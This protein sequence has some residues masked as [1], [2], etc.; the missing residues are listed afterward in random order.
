MPPARREMSKRAEFRSAASL[1]ARSSVEVARNI[2]GER[3][4]TKVEPRT[5]DEVLDLHHITIATSRRRAVFSNEADVR[6]VVR[7]LLELAAAN[8]VAF[9]AGGDHLHLVCAFALADAARR[10]DAMR[11]AVQTVIGV[12]LEP[13]RVSLINGRRH[14]ERVLPYVF[15]QG[16]HHGYDHD[17]AL[18]SGSSIGF[19]LGATWSPHPPAGPA[20]ALPHF[21]ERTALSAVQ[22]SPAALQPASAEEVRSFGA[23]RLREI[24]ASATLSP[25][26]LEGADTITREA[27]RAFVRVGREAGIRRV[28][29]Q[30]ALGIASSTMHSLGIAPAVPELDAAVLRRVRLERFVT[31]SRVAQWRAGEGRP[32]PDERRLGAHR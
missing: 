32:A 28:V 8:L 1:R 14:V 12:E 16:Q 24:V 21:A 30:D 4:T 11:R 15:R 10:A 19:A 25:P 2:F 9:Y 3:P 18:W 7:R 27:R 26:S 17:D 20:L 6:R 31:E 23:E 5:G 22:L 29:L 13:A